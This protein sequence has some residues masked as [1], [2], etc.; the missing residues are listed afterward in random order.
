LHKTTQR[1]ITNGNCSPPMGGS[2][3]DKTAV[4]LAPFMRFFSATFWAGVFASQIP[5]ACPKRQLPRTLSAIFTT[6]FKNY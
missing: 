1:H 2:G 5:I 3:S 6:L 4:G